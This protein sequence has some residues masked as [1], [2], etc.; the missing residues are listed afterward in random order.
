MARALSGGSPAAPAPSPLPGPLP[1]GEE[2][3]WQG[4]PGWRILARRVFHVRGLAAYFAVLL[5]WPA[6]TA[7]YDGGGASAAALAVLR[8]LPLPLAALGLLALIAWLTA[9]ATAYAIT[10]R[11]VVMRIGV[12]LPV[13]VN[14]PFRAVEAAA[15]KLHA[16]GTGDISLALAGDGRMSYVHLWPHARP[17][18]VSRPEPTLR[19][20][21]DAARVADILARALQAVPSAAAGAAPEAR[22]AAPSRQ[23]EA[24]DAAAATPSRPLRAAAA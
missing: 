5:T 8:F 12:A 15:L 2:L 21:P 24:G 6:V 13:T 17:W 4:A 9:R 3:L 22:P 18:R 1:A 16:D 23:P 14:L 19:A 7:V 20:V 11:R 10:T